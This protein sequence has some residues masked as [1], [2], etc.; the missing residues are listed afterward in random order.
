MQ[1]FEHQIESCRNHQLTAVLTFFVLQTW[2]TERLLLICSCLFFLDFE[3][4]QWQLAC[5]RRGAQTVYLRTRTQ[6][7]FSRTRVTSPSCALCLAQVSKV[8][9][10]HDLLRVPPPS[11]SSMSVFNI[12][13][14]PFVSVLSSPTSPPSRPSASSTSMARS[15]RNSPSA[16]AHWSGPGRMANPDQNTIK[17][18]KERVHTK[19]HRVR[20]RKG[21]LTSVPF[22]YSLPEGAKLREPRSQGPFSKCTCK[23]EPRA[24]FGWW[25]DDS[26]SHI[27]HLDTTAYNQTRGL[28]EHQHPIDSRCMVVLREQCA[29]L[30]EEVLLC[31]CNLSGLGEKWCVD[32]MRWYCNLRTRWTT[33]GEQLQGTEIFFVRWYNIM[34][35]LL[36]TC[37]DSAN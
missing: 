26:R 4:R 11:R 19:S 25:L 18:G 24:R 12:P 14:C 21:Y 2:T 23:A 20:S 8:K 6:A 16:S 9:S 7:H 37:P 35:L 28:I 15:C 10:P 29:G 33:I 36:K 27:S 22:F 34:L 3:S 1:G 31:C 13:H 17:F 30:K 5:K 32:A